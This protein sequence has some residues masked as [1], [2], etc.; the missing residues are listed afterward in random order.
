META[1]AKN[2]FSAIDAM[3]DKHGLRVHSAQGEGRSVNQQVFVFKD[4]RTGSQD[5]PVARS[6]FQ[7]TREISLKAPAS[8]KYWITTAKTGQAGSAEGYS[9]DAGTANISESQWV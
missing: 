5:L 7:I 9:S 2:Y 4:L 1:T 8:R 3:Q 6:G